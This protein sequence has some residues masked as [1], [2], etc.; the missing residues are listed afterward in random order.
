MLP[1]VVLPDPVMRVRESLARNIHEVWAKNKIEAGYSYAE[2][3]WLSLSESCSE[4]AI[5][6][7]AHV[8]CSKVRDDNLKQTPL[9]KPFEDLSEGEQRYDYSM[10]LE[11]LSTLVALGYQ[12]SFREGNAAPLQFM[13]LSPERYLQ[14]NGYL[15]RPLNLEGVILS[16]RLTDLVEKL[17]ENAHNVWA[18]SRI[19]EGWTYGTASVSSAPPTGVGCYCP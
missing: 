13:E 10:A 7:D 8:A 19:K 17:A 14:P 18:A 11:T 12:I 1:Q 3:S 2:V 4:Q 5:P 6:F 15:P 9:L 16:E